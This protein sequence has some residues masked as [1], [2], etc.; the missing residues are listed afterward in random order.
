M[1]VIHTSCQADYLASIK[2]PF[3]TIFFQFVEGADIH[4]PAL[5]PEWWTRNKLQSELDF[6]GP[7]VWSH[8]TPDASLSIFSDKCHVIKS[9]TYE[10]HFYSESPPTGNSP[11]NIGLD[12]TSTLRWAPQQRSKMSTESVGLAPANQSLW[13][14]IKSNEINKFVKPSPRS[15][16]EDSKRVA[17]DVLGSDHWAKQKTIFALYKTEHHPW[18]AVD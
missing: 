3:Q 1:N 15:D 18:L 17:I 16:P 2:N 13:K 12:L 14:Q 10:K 8:P 7:I 9:S 5:V 6:W 4:Q 11:P